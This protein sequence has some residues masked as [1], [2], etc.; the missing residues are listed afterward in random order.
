MFVIHNYSLSR[1]IIPPA[2]TLLVQAF[3]EGRFTWDPKGESFLGGKITCLAQGLV[4]VLIVL[5]RHQVFRRLPVEIRLASG[6]TEIV[7]LPIKF[8]LVGSGFG[9]YIHSTN[10]IL[11]HFEFLFC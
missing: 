11:F 5:M 6:A 2:S 10:R 7:C 9:I 1:R 4:M 3:V 8:G